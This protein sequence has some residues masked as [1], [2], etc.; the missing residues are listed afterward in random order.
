MTT[1]DEDEAEEVEEDEEEAE[2]D[3]VEIVNNYEAAQKYLRFFYHFENNVFALFVECGLSREITAHPSPTHTTI[4][5]NI[6]LPLPPDKLLHAAGFKNATQFSL[7]ETNETF[8]IPVPGVIQR[9]SQ[10]A[11]YYPDQETPFWIV[12]KYILEEKKEEEPPMVIKVDLTE[13]LLK[14]KQEKKNNCG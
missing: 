9:N 11:F 7:H 10:R 8:F 3:D 1:E 2:E 5:L 14:F 6:S 12:F 4:E 13:Q